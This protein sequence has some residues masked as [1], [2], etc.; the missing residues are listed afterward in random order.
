MEKSSGDTVRKGML[1]EVF[2]YATD[3]YLLAAEMV[4]SIFLMV[5]RKI[6]TLPEV[7]VQVNG[8]EV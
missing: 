1:E 8:L 5:K 7:T 4:M 6:T 2:V 3:L